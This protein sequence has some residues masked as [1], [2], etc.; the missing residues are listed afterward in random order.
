MIKYVLSSL[1]MVSPVV[2][3]QTLDPLKEYRVC[4]VE[5]KRTASGKILRRADVLRVF[6]TIHP[7]P[8]TGLTEGNC[9]GWSIDHV[10]PLA[11]GGCDSV[12][13]LAWMPLVIKA[14]P[15]DYPKD[16]WERKINCTPTE[17][18]VMPEKALR[19]VIA[20]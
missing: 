7:C 14:G 3:A 13:N 20:P 19:L 15:G 16:R 5:P 2:Q 1:L 10:I 12:H 17:L 9:K 11:C 18:V 4:T 8:S 6:Q